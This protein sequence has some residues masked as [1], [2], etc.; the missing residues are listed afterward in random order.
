[1]K[2]LTLA[3][4]LMSMV[5]A[6]STTTSDY[7]GFTASINGNSYTGYQRMYQYR[8][9][10]LSKIYQTG[11]AKY[12]ACK[13]HKVKR[14]PG[15]C[16]E[17]NFSATVWVEQFYNDATDPKWQQPDAFFVAR[18]LNTNQARAG[19]SLTDPVGRSFYKLQTVNIADYDPLRC[20]KRD[21]D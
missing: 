6:V 14:L 15:W 19:S 18:R 20:E 9:N 8:V 12:A 10:R 16:L 5:A 13:F 3:A 17:K 21:P 2:L 7:N 4:S 1:M 11:D